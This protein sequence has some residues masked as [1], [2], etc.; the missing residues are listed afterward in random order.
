MAKSTDMKVRSRTDV[1]NMFIEIEMAV[2]S[3]TEELDLVCYRNRCTSNL[4]G[5]YRLLSDFSRGLVPKQ[6]ASVLVGLRTRP[7]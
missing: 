7:L 3:D 2:K 1:G 4:N 6:I 5:S